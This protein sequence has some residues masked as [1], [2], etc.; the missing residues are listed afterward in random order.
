[1]FLVPD[2]RGGTRLVTD[3]SAAVQARFDFDAFGNAIAF[4]PSAAL[5][6]YLYDGQQYDSGAGQYYLR[7]RYYNSGIGRFASANNYV[8]PAGDVNNSNLYAYG[9]SSP[10]DA[11]DPSGHDFALI[12]TL[13]LL[14]VEAGLGANA[15]GGVY[16]QAATISNSLAQI[17]NWTLVTIS[18]S[19]GTGQPLS[20]FL[21]GG[22]FNPSVRGLLPWV[23]TT[24]IQDAM[25]RQW[26]VK[27]VSSL[28]KTASA[29]RTSIKME[30]RRISSPVGRGIAEWYRP[31]AQEV[32]R[33]GGTASKT[34][35]WFNTF[36]QRASKVGPILLVVGAAISVYNIATAA[37]PGLQ[38]AREAGG[39]AG[40]ISFGWAGGE[41][42]L[43]AGTALGGP[44]GG[45]IGAFAGGIIGAIYGAELGETAG[46]NIY[47]AF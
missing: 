18:S 29:L 35:A 9:F 7:S 13:G 31:I 2:G 3:A 28:P 24:L 19:S 38:A 36:Y 1:M 15:L 43:A 14:S 16:S 5:T 21:W 17:A 26:Y 10:V 37:D 22:L 8:A 44:V 30:A 11:H 41:V 25:V 32:G 12:T 34:N 46:E 40:A 47:N 33:V 42:G 4:N 45:A 23:G 39:W 6:K 27:N 20:V